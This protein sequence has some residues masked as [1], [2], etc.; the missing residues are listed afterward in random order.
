M[1]WC[2]HE[3]VIPEQTLV[4]SLTHS[5]SKFS[6]EKDQSGLD[7]VIFF[8]TDLGTV[9]TNEKKDIPELVPSEKDPVLSI[10]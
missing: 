10:A 1:E 7:K 3:T 2:Q 6:R 9:L 8:Q 5:V 4:R